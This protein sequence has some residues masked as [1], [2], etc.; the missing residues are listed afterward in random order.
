MFWQ[1]LIFWGYFGGIG[2]SETKLK[3]LLSQEWLSFKDIHDI[4]TYKDFSIDYR[5]T[6]EI[7]TNCFNNRYFDIYFRTSSF[8]FRGKDF[9]EDMSFIGSRMYL[10]YKGDIISN[11]LLSDEFEEYFKTDEEIPK[12]KVIDNQMNPSR[13]INFSNHSNNNDEKLLG[14][15]LFCLRNKE[16]LKI[17][18]GGV[19]FDKLSNTREVDFAIR[20]FIYKDYEIG[21]AKRIV[22]RSGDGREIIKI[23]PMDISHPV[24]EYTAIFIKTIDFMSHFEEILELKPYIDKKDHQSKPT[25]NQDDNYK[26]SEA[27]KPYNDIILAFESRHSYLLNV[28]N[29]AKIQ[30]SNIDDWLDNEKADISNKDDNNIMNLLKGCALKWY[31]DNYTINKKTKTYHLSRDKKRVLKGL[32]SKHYQIK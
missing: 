8:E 1:C 20:N 14:Y 23:T 26:Y 27:L 25:S 32:I 11:N 13:I 12:V 30:M 6:A 19:S 15:S 24:D 10:T 18:V 16:L 31:K 5:D 17:T 7:I 9:E 21:F 4:F 29:R 2:L 28:L 3:F 22:I